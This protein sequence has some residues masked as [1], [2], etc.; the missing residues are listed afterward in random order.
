MTVKSHNFYF[1]SKSR[2]DEAP[3]LRHQLA[4]LLS[5]DPGNVIY[6]FERPY[7]IFSFLNYLLLGELIR[8][9]PDRAGVYIIKY[10]YIIHHKLSFFGFDF[11]NSFVKY[12]C[13]RGIIKY[14]FQCMNPIIVNFNYEYKFLR[15]LFPRSRLVTVI[16]DLH[17]SNTNAFL[18]FLMKRKAKSTLDFSDH[19]VTVS[20]TLAHELCEIT[21]TPVS[22]VYPWSDLPLSPIRSAARN[23][24]KN[25]IDILYWGYISERLDFEYLVMLGSYALS[26]GVDFNF[27]FVGP[28]VFRSK[29]SAKLY[30]RCSFFSFFDECGLEEL[31]LKRSYDISVIPYCEGNLEDIVTEFP[32]KLARLCSQR[33]IVFTSGM[34]N[35]VEAGFIH[36]FSRNVQKDFNK[37]IFSVSNVEILHGEFENFY[38]DNSVESRLSTVYGIITGHY[39][40]PK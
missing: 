11:I 13:I 34:P 39:D 38:R 21:S 4:H 23:S 20:Q 5:R 7:N 35:I 36:K 26:R 40:E 22:V 1:F 2:W 14:H 33:L 18:K 29:K 6:F 32:N 27:H 9:A 8:K 31:L 10:P 30:E 16:N 15:D 12:L 17:W 19:V 28:K 25:N 37:I 24:R 3:R